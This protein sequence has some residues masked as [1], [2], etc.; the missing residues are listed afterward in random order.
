MTQLVL[1]LLVLVA[2][3]TWLIDDWLSDGVIRFVIFWG[4]VCM[5]TLFIILMAV[6]DMLKVVR[7]E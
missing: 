3:G 4:V 1:F 5:Y 2:V 6:Y 7:G